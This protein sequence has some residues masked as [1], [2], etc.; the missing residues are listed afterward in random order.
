MGMSATSELLKVLSEVC[1][2]E[3]LQGRPAHRG[4]C[5]HPGS[6]SQQGHE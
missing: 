6:R 4:A 5:L 1:D 2:G 3:K